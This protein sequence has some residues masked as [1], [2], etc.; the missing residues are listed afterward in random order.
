MLRA[1]PQSTEIADV[2]YEIAADA[3]E[4]YDREKKSAASTDE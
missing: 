1:S 4:P 3:I 2:G